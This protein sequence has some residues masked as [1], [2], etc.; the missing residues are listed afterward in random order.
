[1]GLWVLTLT[2]LKHEERRAMPARMYYLTIFVI[3]LHMDVYLDNDF[4]FGIKHVI[5][6]KYVYLECN[7][8]VHVNLC[9]GIHWSCRSF[10]F[11]SLSCCGTQNRVFW[12]PVV[13]AFQVFNGQL[14]ILDTTLLFSHQASDGIS[15]WSPFF[16]YLT[17]FFLKKDIRL[18]WKLPLSTFH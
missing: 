18:I 8:D 11:N 17:V 13:N 12:V 14:C 6:K 1:M 2:C 5:Q 16:C 4:S 3:V 9:I 10:P 15:Y 7:F